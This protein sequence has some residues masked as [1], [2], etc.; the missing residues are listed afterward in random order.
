MTEFELVTSCFS[1]QKILAYSWITWQ[2]SKIFH[3][4]EMTEDNSS[5]TKKQLHEIM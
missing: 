2:K 1:R 5:S 3:H 4:L